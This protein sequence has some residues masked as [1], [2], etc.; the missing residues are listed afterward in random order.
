MFK[1][2]MLRVLRVEKMAAEKT[3]SSWN[4]DSLVRLGVET[5]KNRIDWGYY[6]ADSLTTKAFKLAVLKQFI[7]CAL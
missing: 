2:V 1:T 4:P 3:N 7:I 5:N 6:L